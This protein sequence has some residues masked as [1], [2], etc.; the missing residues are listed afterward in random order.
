MTLQLLNAI[1]MARSKRPSSANILR[2]LLARAWLSGFIG[3][4]TIKARI[5]MR[6]VRFAKKGD[7][8]QV[9]IGRQR[10]SRYLA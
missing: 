9:A 8:E 5:L 3:Q 4:P 2:H 7:S 1:D 6:G 10:L